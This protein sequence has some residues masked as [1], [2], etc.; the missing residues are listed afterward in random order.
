MITTDAKITTYV[1]VFR[2]TAGVNKKLIQ[3]VDNFSNTG[4]LIQQ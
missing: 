2:I 4:L 3:P 1:L